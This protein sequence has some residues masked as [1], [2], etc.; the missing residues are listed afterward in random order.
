ML[1]GNGGKGLS[2]IASK[3]ETNTLL[4]IQDIARDMVR[5]RKLSG[6]SGLSYAINRLTETTT[7]L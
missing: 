3:K 1:Q 5:W 6:P 4:Q 2:F 7:Y